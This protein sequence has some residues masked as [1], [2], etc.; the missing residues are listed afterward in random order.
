MKDSLEGTRP[1]DMLSLD[2]GSDATSTG[3][4]LKVSVVAGIAG[5][6][7]I[8]A[9]LL[10][11]RHDGEP[12]VRGEE[13]ERTKGPTFDGSRMEK[14]VVADFTPTVASSRRGET[15]L[16]NTY[17]GRG[18]RP[19]YRQVGK[20]GSPARVTLIGKSGLGFT[21]TLPYD[22]ASGPIAA[23]EG[24]IILVR[25]DDWRNRDGG[26]ER[27]V[28]PAERMDAVCGDFRGRDVRRDDPKQD[29][30]R[31]DADEAEK[32]KERER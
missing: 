21:H 5:A 17:D 14:F 25:V 12:I 11:D 29:A 23:R 20:Q 26:L 10:A 1:K 13:P 28:A 8:V 19:E 30:D 32:T 7:L 3:R 27:R 16:V 6:G 2:N 22:C 9:G 31:E 24:R 18:M 4:G 15:V